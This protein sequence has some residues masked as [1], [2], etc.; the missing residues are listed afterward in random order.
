MLL[1]SGTM[2]GPGIVQPSWASEQ[3]VDELAHAANMDPV[4]FRAR[5]ITD[6]RWMAGHDRCR[7]VRELAAERWQ[8]RTC[9]NANIVTG[10]GIS[11]T[12][13]SVYGAVVADITVNK[14]TGKI[15][16]NHIYAAQENGF[17]VGPD[18]V[19]NQM[20]GNVIQSTSRALFRGGDVQQAPG[21]GPRLGDLPDP[22]F[23]G[24]SEGDDGSRSRRSTTRITARASL[25][26]PPDRRSRTRS[27]T[28][29]GR[30]CTRLR[31]PPDAFGRH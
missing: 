7:T 16:V 26:P 24:F 31:C 30:A 25:S 15:V 3:M 27:T 13:E 17:T 2:R 20:V 10:R 19:E 14:K 23:R 21:H 22:S 28:R 11:V 18:L 8:H 4:A 12:A 6:P 29:A 1:R 5:H 9:R